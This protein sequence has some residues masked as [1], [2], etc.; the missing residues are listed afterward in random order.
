MAKPALTAV[1]IANRRAL[2]RARQDETAA[3]VVRGAK[4]FSD[5]PR[6]RW[7]ISALVAEGTITSAQYG[8]AQR[9]SN[10]LERVERAAGG[11]RDVTGYIDPTRGDAALRAYQDACRGRLAREALDALRFH[12]DIP[13][14]QSNRN[15]V[16]RAAFSFPHPSLNTLRRVYCETRANV[17]TV[18]RIL[19]VA[20]ETLEGY[21]ADFDAGRL[22][23]QVDYGGPLR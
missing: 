13:W 7:A 9:L 12:P 6:D 14:E 11:V 18:I 15:R 10:L 22:R 23:F 5:T 4:R 8:A 21:W 16:V 3:G 19:T 17:K 1:E 2:W 20:C